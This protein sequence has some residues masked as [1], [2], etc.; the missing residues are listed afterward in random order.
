MHNRA[1]KLLAALT[2]RDTSPELIVLRGEVEAF[3]ALDSSDA[4]AGAR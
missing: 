2:P 1:E 3:L 4:R